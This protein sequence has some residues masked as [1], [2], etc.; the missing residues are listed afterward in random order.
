MRYL[1]L[2]L[3]AFTALAADE[4]ACGRCEQVREYNA[5]HPE[6]NYTYYEDFLKDQ[7]QKENKPVPELA[8]GSC[9]GKDL[10]PQEREDHLLACCGK[11]GKPKK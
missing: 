1:I 7:A 10:E 8:C 6:K 2:S 9:G 4:A 5:A 11:C 3:I